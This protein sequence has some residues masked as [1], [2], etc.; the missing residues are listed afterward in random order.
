MWIVSPYVAIAARL[1]RAELVLVTRRLDDAARAAL[2]GLAV[3][4]GR[5]GKVERDVAHAVAVLAGA[6]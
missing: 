5:V 1:D 2:H 3:R 4:L 6:A